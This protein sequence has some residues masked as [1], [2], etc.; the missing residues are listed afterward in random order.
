MIEV[1]IDADL[2]EMQFDS[3]KRIVR[4]D[5][6]IRHGRCIPTPA[7]G[8]GMVQGCV[9]VGIDVTEQEG[10]IR[11]LRKSEE[12]LWQMLASRRNSSVYW[13]RGGSAII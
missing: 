1:D 13:A 4:P 12:E 2:L 7:S 6:S 5:G 8:G 9:G 11:A 10:L 3:A